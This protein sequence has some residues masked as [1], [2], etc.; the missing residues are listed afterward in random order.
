[1]P[2]TRQATD[3]FLS[4]TPERVL[5]AVEAAGLRCNTLCYPLNSFENRVYEVELEDRTRRVAKFYRPGRWSAE[6]IQE[7][8][9]FLAELEAEELSVCAVRPFPDGSTLHEIDGIYYSVSDRRAGRAPDELSDASVARL[10]SFVA[11]MHN[12]GARRSANR[13]DLDADHYIRRALERIDEQ[14]SL[15]GI[16][17]AR[18]RTAALA[19]AEIADQMMAGAQTHRIHA[20]LH[21]GNVLFRDEELRV[22]DFDDM[23]HGPA[24]QDLW[25]A[26]PGRDDYTRR[27]R[28]I[29]LESYER[30]RP[31]DRSTLHWIEALRGLRMVRY[32]GWLARR[33]HDP[34]FQTGWPHFGSED[35]WQGEVDDLEEQRIAVEDA[36]AA[37]AQGDPGAAAATSSFG[38]ADRPNEEALTNKDYFWDW[39]GD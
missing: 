14:G 25:L 24:V 38:L 11:R 39:E 12:V 16:L 4:L 20:D 5:A 3:L 8:H 37:G 27:Q 34:A 29:F 13:P 30:F 31:F 33:W 19:I 15:H 6:Q 35:Y 23:V 2:G 9:S 7:E 21:L 36:A 17:R 28:E 10:G 1:M 22:L 26:L 18:Y 32:A